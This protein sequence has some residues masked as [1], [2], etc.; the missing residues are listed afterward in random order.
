M[1]N[2]TVLAV[3]VPYCTPYICYPP[4]QVIRSILMSVAVAPS[5]KGEQG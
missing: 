5:I 2:N 1:N 3:Y 4:E